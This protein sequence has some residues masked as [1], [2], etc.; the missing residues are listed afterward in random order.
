MFICG[1]G[2]VLCWGG[3]DRFGNS[4]RSGDVHP[5]KHQ[6][7]YR[8]KKAEVLVDGEFYQTEF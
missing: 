4:Q 5:Q 2:E 8:F 1:V 6:S 3:S 7:S